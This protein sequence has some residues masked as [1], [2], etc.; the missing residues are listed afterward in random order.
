MVLGIVTDVTLLK[1]K[2]RMVG[3]GWDW[4]YLAGGT[5]GGHMTEFALMKLM[6]GLCGFFLLPLSPLVLFPHYTQPQLTHGRRVFVYSRD[7]ACSS[8]YEGQ[9]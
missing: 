5:A 8:L 1:N 3:L 6:W 4:L 9:S 2:E 7:G